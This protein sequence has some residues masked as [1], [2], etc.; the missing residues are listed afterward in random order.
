MYLN[1]LD[2][3][4]FI[5]DNNI[6]EV[7]NANYPSNKGYDENSLWS[8]TIFGRQNS[9]ERLKRFGYIN[10]HTKII[11]PILYKL[12]Q[13]V[14]PFTRNLILSKQNYRIEKGKFIEDNETGLTGIPFL[15]NN[16]NNFKFENVCKPDKQK[17]ALYLDSIKQFIGIDKFLILPAGMRDI[18]P[19]S[20]KIYST[21]INDYYSHIIFLSN[22]MK[23][24]L[25]EI[26]AA[27]LVENLQKVA[28]QIHYWIQ[29]QL[30]GK[31]GIYRSTIL[32]KVIDYSARF[33]ATGSPKIPLGKIGLPWHSVLILFEPFFF[34]YVFHKDPILK[35]QISLYLNVEPGDLKINTLKQFILSFVKAT[36]DIP[37]GLKQLLIGAAKQ[38]SEGKQVLCKRDPVVSRTSYYSG[39][40]LV[41]ESGKNAVLSTLS[42]KQQNLDFD[43]DQVAIIPIFT[44]EATEQAKKL[45]PTIS[46]SAWINPV[47]YDS[48][49]YYLTLDAMATV[50]SATK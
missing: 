7:T 25:D 2:I 12:L 8:E 31:S 19:G 5:K 49:N 26:A 38:I 48:N 39:E 34:N 32:K 20:K 1:L 28:L 37:D 23:I 46:K 27:A 14:S 29:I 41:L 30:K 43:G 11:N 40:I 33:V 16:L 4:R 47:N 24:Q 42:C 17:E 21:E 45:N 6:L 10:L 50:Y 15:L 22:Q 44:T 3:N 13:V 18:F 35:E 36:I 9:N